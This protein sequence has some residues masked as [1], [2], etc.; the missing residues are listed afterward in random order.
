MNGLCKPSLKAPGHVTKMLPAKHGQKVDGFEPIS[1]GK[2]GFWWKMICAFE[3]TI[4][5]LSFWYVRLAQ[6]EYYFSSFF[7]FFF[8]SYLLLNR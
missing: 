4:N 2:Y 6:P 3:H 8:S 1:A 7:F 5:R